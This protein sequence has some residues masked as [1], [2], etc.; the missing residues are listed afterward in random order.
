MPVMLPDWPPGTVALLVTIGEEP[1]AIPV[2]AVLRASSTRILLGLAASRGSLGR[3][4]REPRVAVA[5]LG[6]D[7]ALTAGG[8]ARVLD[9]PLVDR[10]AAVEI[11]VDSVR[12][13]RRPTFEIESGVR[14]RWTDPEAAARDRQ[15]R[16][17]L[18]R[19][20]GSGPAGPS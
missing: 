10:V 11:E 7:L 17:A 13:H 8:V 6:P 5:L 14:W 12:D 18:E 15:V 16:S 2:S 19:L 1:H 9:E 3:L 20:A 4:R